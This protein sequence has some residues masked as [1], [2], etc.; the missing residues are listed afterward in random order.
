MKAAIPSADGNEHFGFLQ[1]Y[2]LTVFVTRLSEQLAME[3][4]CLRLCEYLL[5]KLG[6]TQ[7]GGPSREVLQQLVKE[8]RAHVDSLGE[9]LRWLGQDPMHATSSALVYSVSESLLTILRDPQTR[10]PQGLQA[11]YMAEQ[12]AVDSWQGLTKLTRLMGLREMAADFERA[13]TESAVH[14][15]T[16][17]SWISLELS[18]VAY[19][20]PGSDAL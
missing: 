18:P 5:L 4:T 11:M 17:R 20:E 8:K 14:L 1:G 6:A 9:A 2:K 3:R 16:V 13:H 15:E 19:P 12:A 10:V 7:A